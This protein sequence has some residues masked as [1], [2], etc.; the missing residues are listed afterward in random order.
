M[1]FRSPVKDK[2][3]LYLMTGIYKIAKVYKP[4]EYELT[5][6]GN[7]GTIR[8]KEEIGEGVILDI[9]AGNQWPTYFDRDEIIFRRKQCLT[10]NTWDSQYQLQAKPLHEVRLN[11]DLMPVYDNEV[12]IRTVNKEIAITLDGTPITTVRAHWDC[13]KGKKTSDESIFS[14]MFGDDH[15]NH[16]WHCN[17]VLEGEVFDQCRKVAKRVIQ[18]Q[19][20][21]IIIE[22]NGIGGF[23]PSILKRVFKE[24]GVVGCGI[25]EKNV[26]TNKT[27]RILE[28]FEPLLSA[29]LLHVRR[30]VLDDGLD[31]Q[32]RDWIPTAKNQKDDKLDGGAGC[33][34]NMPNTVG[35]IVKGAD[36][37]KTYRGGY[38]PHGQGH[39][40]KVDAAPRNNN[41]RI[42]QSFEIKTG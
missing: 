12:E 32:M 39:V 35:K 28:A 37:V 16:H 25:I 21:G 24:K 8:L 14:L 19:I 18:Y 1:L 26:S 6:T 38:R 4:H 17:D 23:L 29:R 15:G 9:A 10:L 27:T 30:S 33:I 22:T 5:L 36:P 34:R 20:P 2:E 13:S 11:P 42:G 31:G 41:L 40:V 7:G 3:D